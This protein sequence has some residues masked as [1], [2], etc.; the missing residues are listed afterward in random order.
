[1]PIVRVEGS[2]GF[3]SATGTIFIKATIVGIELRC[4]EW[5]VADYCKKKVTVTG[6]KS[7][8]VTVFYF[9]QYFL[10]RRFSGHARHNR[11]L[12]EGK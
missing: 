6:W 4:G 2:E 5:S 10:C 12:K 8:P 3:Y 1:V 11:L 7:V 9:P